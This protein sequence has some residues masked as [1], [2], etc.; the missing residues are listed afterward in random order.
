M[1]RFVAFKIYLVGDR[2]VI[3]GGNGEFKKSLGFRFG[4]IFY[5]RFDMLVMIVFTFW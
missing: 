3:V 2:M 5:A 4:K 1:E